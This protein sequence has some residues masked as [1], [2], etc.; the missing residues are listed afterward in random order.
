ME[1][2]THNATGKPMK[3]E[4]LLGD[5]EIGAQL[6]TKRATMEIEPVLARLTV[7]VKSATALVR[8]IRHPIAS[9]YRWTYLS[10]CILLPFHY[11]LVF[12]LLKSQSSCCLDILCHRGYFICSPC[13]KLCCTCFSWVTCNPCSALYENEDVDVDAV[14]CTC[15][16][17]RR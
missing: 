10:F 8:R 4:L 13:R 16:T 6:E 11:H 17:E 1:N 12:L 7:A 5:D 15:L 2:K 14:S 3:L 9:T